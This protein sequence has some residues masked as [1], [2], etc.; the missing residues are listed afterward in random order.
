MSQL[1]ITLVVDNAT[2]RQAIGIKEALAMDMEEKYGGSVYVVQVDVW[3]PEQL[4][5]GETYE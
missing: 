1:V 2:P 5:M 4:G 3:D